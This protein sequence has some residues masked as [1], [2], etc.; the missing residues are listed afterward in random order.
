M[1]KFI[2]DLLEAW[3]EAREAYIKARMIDGYWL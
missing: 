1:R 2:T 3:I